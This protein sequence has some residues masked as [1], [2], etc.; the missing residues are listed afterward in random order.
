METSY[1]FKLL[2][3]TDEEIEVSLQLGGGSLT[4]GA[5]DPLKGLET[6]FLSS[7]VSRGPPTVGSEEKE[8][9]GGSKFI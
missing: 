3:C 6:K 2:H 8:Y 9:G 1:L 5:E 4:W 7:D